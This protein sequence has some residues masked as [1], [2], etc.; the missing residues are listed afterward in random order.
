LNWAVYQRDATRYAPADH[1]VAWGQAA[2]PAPI[3]HSVIAPAPARVEQAF[4]RVKLAHP[5]GS[6]PVQATFDLESG[7][8]IEITRGDQSLRFAGPTLNA[9]RGPTDNDGIKLHHGQDHKILTQWLKLGLDR[10]ES[11]LDGLR[12]VEVG[13]GEG[14]QAVETVHRHTGRGNWDDF[15][16][17]QRYTLLDDGDLLV[18]NTLTLGEGVRDLPRVGVKLVLPP[19]LE[20]LT[21]YG[22]GPRENYADRKVSSPVGRY[23]ST[24]T[25]QYVPYIMPQEH[26]AHTDVRWLTLTDEA[27]RG[28]RVAGEPSIAFT[29]SHFTADDLYQARHT[30]DITPRP[31]VYLSID[32][33]QRG[34]GT[35]SCGPDTLDQYRL[36]DSMYRFAYRL[37]LV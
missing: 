11:R 1:E 37:R 34:L 36:L 10:L 2:L 21:F 9:W 33:A 15:V 23:E 5:N 29:A 25:D 27:G 14:G 12:V 8:L 18:E 31:N 3:A 17:T 24:V 32:L 30:T 13:A 19:T 20:N 26:G 4:T 28:L 35:A 22:R 6:D 16:H 7:D